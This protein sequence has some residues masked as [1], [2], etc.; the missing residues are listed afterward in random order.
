MTKLVKKLRH[1]ISWRLDLLGPKI[2]RF[3]GPLA[4]ERYVFYRKHGYIPHL[5]HPRTFSE[6]ICHRKLFRPALHS[7]MLADKFAVRAY[8]ERCGL[9]EMLAKLLLVTNEPEKIDFDVLPNRFVIKATHGSGWNILV[10][11]KSRIDKAAIVAQCRKWL[12]SA[13]GVS[14]KEHHYKDIPPAIIIE[15]FLTDQQHDVPLDYK[16]FVFHGKCH[17]IQVDYARFSEHTRT[18][19][20]PEWEPQDF[21]LMYP[22]TVIQERKPATLTRMIEVAET[23][24]KDIDFCRVDLY[25]INDQ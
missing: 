16:F 24:A 4:E 2:G 17:F 19:Y 18:F 6:K 10:R 3:I 9:A 23:L 14:L 15:E 5:K 12:G 8:V 20:S 13:Y 11:D 25:S 22:S 21:T 7:A 1:G